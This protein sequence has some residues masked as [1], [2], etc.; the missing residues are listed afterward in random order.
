MMLPFGLNGCMGPQYGVLSRDFLLKNTRQSN[1][2][3]LNVEMKI[4]WRKEETYLC[5]WMRPACVYLQYIPEI[6]TKLLS[7]ICYIHRQRIHSQLTHTVKTSAYTFLVRSKAQR[8][9]EHILYDIY[10]I[11]GDVCVRFLAISN[12]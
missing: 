10:G 6:E 5:I 9:H 2:P 4:M 7:R 12:R 3:V 11:T 1:T 8:N